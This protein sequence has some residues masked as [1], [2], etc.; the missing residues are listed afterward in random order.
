MWNVGDNGGVICLDKSRN[1]KK[2]RADLAHELGHAFLDFQ[3]R[4]LGS[5]H[6]V[7]RASNT[8]GSVDAPGCAQTLV[9]QAPYFRNVVVVGVAVIA[10]AVPATSA[11][12]PAAVGAV[13]AIAYPL[14][15]AVFVVVAAIAA[16]AGTAKLSI[17]PLKFPEWLPW[18]SHA[19]FFV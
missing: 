6:T 14:A 10:I 1:V 3:A 13:A 9:R 18:L 11:V 12:A 7:P 19:A 4:A 17:S 16:V 2:R 8:A 15:A 5:V